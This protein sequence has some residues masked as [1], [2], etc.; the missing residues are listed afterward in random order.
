L[1]LGIGWLA[2]IAASAYIAMRLILNEATEA[3]VTAE[4]AR[5]T[6]TAPSRVMTAPHPL[7]P[8][9]WDIVTQTGEVYRY[10]RY[11]WRSGLTLAEDRL[12]VAQPSP[13]WDAARRDPSVRGF[14]T[15]MRFP[16]YEV[17]RDGEGTRVLIHDARYAV[18]RLSGGGFGGVVV[19]LPESGN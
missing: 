15:W 8:L 16:W 3:K 10:G 19:H 2:L 1:I 17:E 14:V 6:Q 9:R 12:P 5:A 4:V 11:H 13:E 7:D 18:R